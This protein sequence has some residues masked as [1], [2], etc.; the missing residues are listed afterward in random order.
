MSTKLT[1]T[2]E[3]EVI[4]KAKKYAKQK[5]RSLSDLV[6]NYF[7]AITMTEEPIQKPIGSVASALLGS[8]KEPEN[9]NYKRE[10]EDALT[11]KYL[12]NG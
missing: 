2:I 8:V 5:G 4:K 7:R 10:L 6:E 1:L 3:Q 11:E 9:F 12:K